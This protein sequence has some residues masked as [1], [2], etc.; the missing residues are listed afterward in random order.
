[1]AKRKKMTSTTASD[2]TIRLTR[3]ERARIEK[4]A[5]ADFLPVSTWLRRLALRAVVA[6]DEEKAREARRKEWLA[7]MREQL[8]SL[9]DG[10][11]HA[12]EVERARRKDWGRR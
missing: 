1:M 10:S 9:P 2:L 8:W 5:E 6:V 11:A 3:E 7:R 12:D 4:V